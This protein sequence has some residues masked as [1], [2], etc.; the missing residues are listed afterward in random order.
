MSDAF[1]GV[2]PPKTLNPT[3]PT[4]HTPACPQTAACGLWDG[5]TYGPV[6]YWCIDCSTNL[7]RVRDMLELEK[8]ERR[9]TWASTGNGMK[10]LSRGPLCPTPGCGEPRPVGRVLC[11]VCRAEGVE[12]DQAA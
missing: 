1:S 4:C 11:A 12:E 5:S 8:D 2:L 9:A 3:H 10:A 6:P 7:G